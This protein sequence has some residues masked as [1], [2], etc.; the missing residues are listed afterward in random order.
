MNLFPIPPKSYTLSLLLCFAPISNYQILPNTND[1]H[2]YLLHCILHHYYKSFQLRKDRD[3]P[4]LFVFLYFSL[5]N[6]SWT[7]LDTF[8]FKVPSRQPVPSRQ[9]SCYCHYELSHCIPIIDVVMYSKKFYYVSYLLKLRYQQNLQQNTI[10]YLSFIC[11][12]L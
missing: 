8:S 2:L 11:F 6:L 9:C 5:C 7:V 12:L 1:M 10:Q 3:K 4:L